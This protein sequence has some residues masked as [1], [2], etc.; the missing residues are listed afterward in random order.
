MRTVNLIDH[1]SD[2]SECSTGDAAENVV[3]NV[4]GDGAPLFVL[5]SRLN[6]QQF[7]TMCDSGLP[8]TIFTGG[9]EKKPTAGGDTCQA[10]S[11]T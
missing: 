3:L 9:F 8:I 4:N 10:T 11:E 2:R 6:N 5:K 7:S 1:Q